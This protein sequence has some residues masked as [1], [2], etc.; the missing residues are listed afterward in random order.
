MTA[1]CYAC[2]ASSADCTHTNSATAG[3][4]GKGVASYAQAVTFKFKQDGTAGTDVLSVKDVTYQPNTKTAI[5]R[6]FFK[7]STT[8]PLYATSTI[9]Y[10]F[11]SQT[12]GNNAVC[13]VFTSN[14][15]QP[16]MTHSDLVNNCV[17]SGSSVTVTMAKAS[18]ANFHVQIV[19]MDAWLAS[20]TNSVTGTVSNFGQAV[21]TQNSDATKQVKMA[22]VGT[23]TASSNEPLATMTAVVARS[24]VNVMDIGMISF[25]VTPKKWD[26]GADGL[27]FI[28][29]P[30][31]YNPTIG[32]MMRCSLY[33]VKGKKDGERL[34]CA[35]AW[36]YT[37]QVWGPANAQKKD[38]AFE[39]RVYGVAM[40]LH[41][42][43]GNFGVG[44]TNA[45]YWA[46]D[47]K[48][49]EFK[50]AAD[51]TTGVWGGKL[52]IDVTSVTSTSNN[53]RAST[54]LTIN[55]NLP[56]TT[57]TVTQD[58]D[59][60]AV[61]LPYQ[62]MGVCSWADAT[63][64][65]SASL[66]LVTTTGTGAAAKTTKSAMKGSVSQFSGSHVVFALDTTVATNKLAEGKAYEMVLSGV[67]TAWNG[68]Y[69]PRMNLGSLVLSVGKV[70]TGGF[71][72]SSAQLFNAL[73]AQAAATGLALLEFANQQVTISRGTYTRNAVC[74]QPAKGNFAADVSAKPNNANFKIFPASL[75]AKMGASQ[76]CAAMGTGSTTQ[77]S[78]HNVY[79]T[80]E[81]GTN[82]YTNLPTMMATV[83][84]AIA[85]V[86][87]PDAVTC[88]LGGSSVP[89]VVTAT[90]SPFSDIKV[91][92]KTSIAADEKKTDNSVGITPNTG[93]V[94]TLNV[95]TESGTLGFKCAATVTGKELKYDLAGTDKAQFALSATVITVTAAKAGTK[96]ASPK[97]TLAMVDASS[98]AAST[99]VQGECPGMGSAWI[100]MMPRSWGSKP[101]ASAAD[102]RTAMGKRSLLHNG[103]QWCSQAV[104]TAGAK[105]TCTFASASKGEYSAALYCETIEGWF[106]ASNKMVNVTAKDN[107]GKPVSLTLTYSKAID[108]VANNGV[109]LKICGKLA[110]NMAVPYNR[111]TDQYGGFFGQ[112]SASLPAATA[113]PAA[114][115][116]TTTN[117]T[118]RMLNATNATTP[119]K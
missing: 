37:L 105:T 55:F 28:S 45:T 59:F 87:V 97:M 6:F 63:A 4:N 42:A 117:K 22:I 33:D 47:S 93:E 85:T 68:Q 102:V 104:A 101:L 74:I 26:W 99:V 8:M 106:F 11:G 35:V 43:A 86:N 38:A 98:K 103:D 21:Q 66:K 36:D 119:A 79:W 112:P 82:A 90:A 77:M 111:V 116:N 44:L 54:D 80:V 60:V 17:V 53:M 56:A 76:A 25:T 2:Q 107:G 19:G 72:Y 114:A 7:P 61:Q 94:V 110:E 115:T 39:L 91:S 113:K 84:G 100:N 92:L 88:S 1:S 30:T 83:N 62:W 40:N 48:L 73:P 14:G 49:V 50:T 9:A 16:S 10:T 67:P 70:A 12:F 108:V 13:S 23:T 18:A 89:I 46:S 58:S 64:T 34:Y 118:M 27:M 32:N 65:P 3:A 109:V 24:L 75:S 20:A 15:N 5:G 78:T 95:N 51:T 69:G 31:Y 29:F 96:P 57:D 41:G 52:A 81:N 71:G